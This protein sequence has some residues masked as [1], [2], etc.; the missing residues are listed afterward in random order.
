MEWN[1][2][3]VHSSVSFSVRHMVIASVKGSFSRFSLDAAIDD[4]N[5]PASRGT[6]RIEAASIDTREPQRD[7][8][9]R[10]ADFLDADNYPELVFLAKRIEPRGGSDYRITGDLTIRGVTKEVTLNAEV[11]G[12][13][14][15]P[16]GGTRV[17]VEAEGKINR[18]DFGLNWNAVLEAGGF[19]VG[20]EVKLTVDLELV[21]VAEPAETATA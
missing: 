16:W 1:L 20:D 10:S 7:G 6:L 4:T 5:L 3:P 21:K 18:K 13:L 14:K 19:V 11:N 8:H 15:D 12:P 17:G 2:D 9:L